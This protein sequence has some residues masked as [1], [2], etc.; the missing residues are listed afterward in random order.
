MN[1]RLTILW[2]GV[3]SVALAVLVPAWIG[4]R[5]AAREATACVNEA[6]EVA[7]LA[8]RASALKQELPAW[9]DRSATSEPDG[10]VAQAFTGV[11]N[12]LGFPSSALGSISPATVT[13]L[14][15][16]NLPEAARPKRVQHTVTLDS[17]TLVQIGRVLTRW[18]ESH[19]AWTVTAITLTHLKSEP[20]SKS[21]RKGGLL[22]VSLTVESIQLGSAPR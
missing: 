15:S 8:N 17:V 3:S 7:D 22:R 2:S 6:A 20:G 19:P 18:R 11:L 13:P 10:T 16:A 14:G 12:D 5:A 9:T 1:L 4:E 21:S